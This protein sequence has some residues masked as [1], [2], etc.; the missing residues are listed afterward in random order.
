MTA[1]RETERKYEAADAMELPD[2]AELPGLATGAAPQEQ[3]LEAVYFDTP[4]L[5]LVRAGVTLRR[6]AGGS[7][8]GWHLKLPVGKDSRDELRMPARSSRRQPPAALV[9]LTRVHSRGAAL[10]PVAQLN[11]RRRRWVLTD[12]DGHPLAELVEDRVSAHTMGEQTRALSWREVEVELAEHG[13]VNLLNRIGRWLLHAG[14]RRS[15][16]PSKLGRLLAEELQ[17]SRAAPRPASPSSAGGVVLAYLT[18]Q[19]EQLR[20]Y[21]PLVRR[22]A[23][24][25]VHQMRV[26]GRRMRSALQAFGQLIDRDQTRALTAELKWISGELSGARDAE[27][28]AQRC[29]TI[30]A[31]LPDE[32]VLGPVAAALTRSFERR[33]ADARDVAL[34]AL[35]SDRY[36]AL[37][38]AIDAL[39]ADPPLT[40]AAT[41]SGRRELPK[42]AA[43]AYPRVAS[44]MDDALSQPSGA[45]RDLALHEA[46]KAT[47]RLR[48]T[49]EAITPTLGKSARRSQR[50]LKKVQK[51]LGSHQD[52]VVS[53]PVLRELAGKAHLDGGNGFTYGLM[54]A[55]EAARAARA[56][57]DLPAAWRHMLK[58]KNITW[59]K[60]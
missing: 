34:T 8:P 35:N 28:M 60:H 43:R 4:D 3:H 7:D 27:V 11:T 32:L 44:R 2:P 14:A 50:P 25:A 18:T 12:A 10:A 42:S 1:I 19:A 48:Y 17:T 29:A 23:P 26:A 59:L 51:L 30:L 52:T 24:D 46:R 31:G 53:R 49:T 6:R 16:S 9:E 41:R 21:D 15:G 22:D 57:R 56:E 54:H 33:Q 5:R 40:R 39:L 37:H 55:V 45:Q 38:D 36:L 20:S 58:P 47:K 13:D